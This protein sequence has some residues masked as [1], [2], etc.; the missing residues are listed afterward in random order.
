[1]QVWTTCLA[2][3][4]ALSIIASAS[5]QQRAPSAPDPAS[6]WKKHTF[7]DDRFEIE[8]SGP[9][10]SEPVPLD[11]Q[12]RRRVVRSTQHVQDGAKA[13]YIVGAQQNTD[14]VNFDAGVKGSFGALKC[15][16]TEPEV[17]VPV[18]TGRGRELKG[19]DCFNG[20]MRAEARYF[21]IGKWFY[22]VMA[23]YPTDGDNAAARRFLESFKAVGR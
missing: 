2:G 3:A 23:L 5:A 14:V 4:L 7:S 1:M 17:A 20:T 11:P 10:R 19:S 12:S 21:E 16:S 15:K 22:Q 13:I 8:F 18:G 9:V 6:D